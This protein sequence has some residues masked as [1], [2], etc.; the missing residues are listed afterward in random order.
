MTQCR[1]LLGWAGL[2]LC[3]ILL[4]GCSKSDKQ[5]RAL[6]AIS[7]EIIRCVLHPGVVYAYR[8]QE[9]T[10]RL[11][12]TEGRVDIYDSGMIIIT[13]RDGTKHC[14]GTPQFS[15]ITFK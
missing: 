7:G 3:L 1:N 13:E 8:E 11:V 6:P 5:Q 15:E 4:V 12:F 2:P 10:N 14:A 9:S